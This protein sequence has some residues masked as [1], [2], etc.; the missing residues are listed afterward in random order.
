MERDRVQQAPMCLA[1]KRDSTAKGRL[2]CN[3]KPTREWL[4]KEA[5][6]SLTVGLDSLFLTMMIDAREARDAMRADAPNA[7]TQM[8]IK[9]MDAKDETVMKIAG[10]F[11][12]LSVNNSPEVHGASRHR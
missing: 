11:V 1:E 9:K 12:D 5:S 8:L 2:V 10:V 3:G 4:D 7:F 6:S